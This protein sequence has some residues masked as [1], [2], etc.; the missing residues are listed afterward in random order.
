MEIAHKFESH[1]VCFCRH[2][3]RTDFTCKIN[4][5]SNF[6]E[7]VDF[8]KNVL[9]SLFLKKNAKMFHG[10]GQDIFC[11]KLLVVGDFETLFKGCKG[12]ENS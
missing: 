5:K 8:Q 1:T 12:S 11:T 9:T 7:P 3:F 6:R 2:K 10:L 4:C